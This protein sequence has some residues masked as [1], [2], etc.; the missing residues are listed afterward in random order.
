MKKLFIG[1]LLSLSVVCIAQERYVNIDGQK[2]RIKTG[3]TGGVT[4]L[5]ENGMSDSLEV[6][7]SIPDSVAAFAKYFLYDRADIGKSDTSRRAR[8]IPNMVNELRGILNSKGI[9]MLF[10]NTRS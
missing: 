5:F 2:F 6:W 9:I 4:V 1:C 8:T 7:H 10:R 3:D